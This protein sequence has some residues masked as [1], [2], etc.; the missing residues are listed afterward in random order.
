[1]DQRTKAYW[2]KSVENR[3]VS[4]HA[5]ENGQFNAAAS[6]YYYALRLAI[7]AL[8]E[9]RGVP[10]PKKLWRREKWVEN[11]KKYWPWQELH[12]QASKELQSYSNNIMKLLKRAW[13]LRVRGDYK[14]IHVEEKS[15]DLLK[16]DLDRLFEVI[17]S[18][19]TTN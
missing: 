12:V 3:S 9:E 6:R 8:F 11:N 1:M 10:I 7:N 4:E 15:I 18:E 17:E 13:K 14:D 5:F 2:N 16:R 19:I